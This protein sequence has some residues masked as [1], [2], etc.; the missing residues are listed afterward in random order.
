MQL[1]SGVSLP[2]YWLSNLIA[3]ISKT[4]VPILITLVLMQIYGVEYDGAWVLLLL[5]PIAIVPFTYVTSFAFSNDTVAQIMTIFLHFLFGA[6]APIIVISLQSIES[7]ADTGDSLRYAFTFVPTYC[8]GHGVIVSAITGSLV[9]VREAYIINGA[10]LPT[11]SDNVFALENIGADILMM[12]VIAAFCTLVL[13]LVE[14]DIFQFCSRCSVWS[15]P[16]PRL[17]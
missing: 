7:T 15:Q 17:V 4:F 1:I 6:I 2:A 10:D 9:Q 12:L 8:V 14:A 11:I 13:F 5:Y 16:P 3:D